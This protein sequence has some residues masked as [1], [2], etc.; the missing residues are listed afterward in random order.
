MGSKEALLNFRLDQLTSLPNADKDLLARRGGVQAMR[1]AT[2]IS[3]K[4]EMDMSFSEIVMPAA[5]GCSQKLGV[6]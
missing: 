5:M 1:V 3:P 6:S 4:D 2:L